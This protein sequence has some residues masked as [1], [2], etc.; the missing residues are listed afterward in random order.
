[1]IVPADPVSHGNLCTV[2]PVRASLIVLNY[3]GA[4]VLGPCLS[5]LLHDLGPDD[6]II[7][8]DNASADG[9]VSLVPDDPRVRLVQNDENRFIFGLNDGLAV[10]RGRFVAFLNNDIEVRPGFLDRMVDAFT[11]EEVFAVCPRIYDRH[12]ADQGA[13]T[14]GHFVRGLF[15]YRS[16]PHRELPSTIF[17][18]VGGQSLFDRDKLVHLGSI[19]ELLWPMY[20]EDIELS[21]RAWKAG[22]EIRYAPD[23]E[24]DHVGGHSSGRRFS[25]TELRSFVR[26]NEYLTVWKNV[27]DPAMLATHLMLLPLRLLAALVKRD[28]ATLVGFGRAARVAPLVVGRRRV[29]KR[30]FAISD[31]EVLNRVGVVRDAS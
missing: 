10:A 3:N 26:Q 29:A 16:H 28:F 6:E 31:R 18:A 22:Y 19:D 20:H 1:M 9:S 25:A 30:H 15:F 7:V 8:V 24:V 11:T 23:A 5:S 2:N 13:V 17:F 12:G 14:T 21:Y 27:T 4:E